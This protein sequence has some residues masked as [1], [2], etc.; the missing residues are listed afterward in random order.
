MFIFIFIIINTYIYIFNIYIFV[1]IRM[2]DIFKVCILF[3]FSRLFFFGVDE[4]LYH[5][6]DNRFAKRGYLSQDEIDY[7]SL[8]LTIFHWGFAAWR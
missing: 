7:W 8:T 2:Y 3:Y 5:Q 1:C 4:P 6:V